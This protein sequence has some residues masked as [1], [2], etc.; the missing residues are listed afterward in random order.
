MCRSYRS[1]DLMRQLGQ[2][3]SQVNIFRPD[4]VT[5]TKWLEHLERERRE[6][7]A[8]TRSGEGLPETEEASESHQ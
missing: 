6:H 1:E 7:G 3:V 4:G 5:L 2:G 8:A